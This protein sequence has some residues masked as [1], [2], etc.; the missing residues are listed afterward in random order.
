[1][2]MVSMQNWKILKTELTHTGK[3]LIKQWLLYFLNCKVAYKFLQEAL[4]YI[5]LIPL[6]SNQKITNKNYLSCLTKKYLCL[7]YYIGPLSIILTQR[8]FMINAKIHLI[9]L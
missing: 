6:S 5:F 9:P 4:N 3:L 7:N 2:S 8:F 1:M